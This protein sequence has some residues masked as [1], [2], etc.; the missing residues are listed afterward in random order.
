MLDSSDRTCVGSTKFNSLGRE[1]K[2]GRMRQRS[3]VGYRSKWVFSWSVEFDFFPK[4]S[5]VSMYLIWLDIPSN[6][7]WPS[8]FR[9][10]LKNSGVQLKSCT[11]W[12]NPERNELRK[13]RLN[14]R[15]YVRRS[16]GNTGLFHLGFRIIIAVQNF[17]G[18]YHPR[19][20]WILMIII[21]TLDN[22]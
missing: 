13:D 18:N 3:R 14:Q 15:S 5:V 12:I 9:W 7:N 16:Y 21:L 6:N 8:I 1:K 20:K 2:A 4:W 22:A 10:Q 19:L 11:F 17:T